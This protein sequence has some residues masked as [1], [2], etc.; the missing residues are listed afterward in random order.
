MASTENEGTK[1]VL[2]TSTRDGSVALVEY[3]VSTHGALVPS[4]ASGV[5]FKSHP[6]N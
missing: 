4:L 3:A 5:K 2:G 1:E 6:V